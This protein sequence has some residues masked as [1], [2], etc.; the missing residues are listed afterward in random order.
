MDQ[1]LLCSLYFSLFLKSSAHNGYLMPVHHCIPGGRDNIALWLTSL[2]SESNGTRGAIHKELY[3]NS[4]PAP[5]SDLGDKILDLK[6]EPDA[7]LLGKTPPSA[8]FG[9]TYTKPGII[10]SRLAGL[11]H[12]DDIHIHEVFIFT[13]NKTKKLSEKG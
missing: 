11:L 3:P 13:Q 1:Q 12:K 5:G 7:V 6:P 4:L 10:Q 9:S 2:Q 8:H